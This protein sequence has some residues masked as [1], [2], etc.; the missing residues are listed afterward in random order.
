MSFKI[1]LFT[2]L[3]LYFYIT[4]KAQ[5]KINST[6]LL[7]KKQKNINSIMIWLLPFIWYYLIKHIIKS[8]DSIMTKAKR[9]TMRKSAGFSGDGSSGVGLV[10]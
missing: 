6:N 10:P 4:I 7:T 2:L 9:K 1:F 3:L 8:D 5:R